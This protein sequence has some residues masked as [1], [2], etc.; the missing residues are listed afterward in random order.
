MVETQ[1]FQIVNFSKAFDRDSFFS[2]NLEIDSWLKVYAGQQE[3]SGAS[4]TYLLVDPNN[5]EVVGYFAVGI[6]LYFPS[7]NLH[8]KAAK[9]GR[10]MLELFRLG[11]SANWQGQGLASRMI[12]ETFQIALHVAESVGVQGVLVQPLSQNLTDFYTKFGFREFRTDPFEMAIG[13]GAIRQAAML[14]VLTRQV[15]DKDNDNKN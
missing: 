6:G 12:R 13:I 5:N 15:Q 11:V 14:N 1:K 3:T 8:V 7:P 2:G 9:Y 4:R 10:R